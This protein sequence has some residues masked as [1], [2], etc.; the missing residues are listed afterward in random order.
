MNKDWSEKNKRVQQ[1][2]KK[3]TFSEGIT[4]L[5]SLRDTLMA[6]IFSWKRELKSEAF[7]AMPYMNSKGYHSKTIAYSLW[8]IFR[9]EDIVANSLIQGREQVF[10]SG[11]FDKKTRSPII[12]TGNELIKEQI[13]DFSGQLDIA[14]LYEYINAVKESTD[15]WLKSIGYDDLKRRFTE[16][17]KRRLISLGPVSDDENAAWLIDYWCGKDVKGLILMPFS[18]HWI[19]HIE[20]A[21]RIK[22]KLQKKKRTAY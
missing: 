19:M 2:L 20:A 9:I 8:H 21:L 15:K 4:G 14:A 11:G 10:F 12:T 7:S 5:L 22:A 18:R 6:E 3:S 16:E 13:A 1:L 17:D